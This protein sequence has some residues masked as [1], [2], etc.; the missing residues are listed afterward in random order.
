MSCRAGECFGSLRPATYSALRATVIF[1]I[2]DEQ[3]FL[4]KTSCNHKSTSNATDLA[5]CPMFG[6]AASSARFGPTIKGYDNQE[7]RK[8]SCMNVSGTGRTQL[9]ERRGPGRRGGLVSARRHA[10][11]E[12]H[13]QDNRCT[14]SHSRLQDQAVWLV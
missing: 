4:S 13:R 6:N 10:R 14:A 8:T 1:H 3:Y 2:S 9:D 12:R 7:F 5:D 11:S